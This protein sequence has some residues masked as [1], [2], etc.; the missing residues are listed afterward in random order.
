L[1]ISLVAFTGGGWKETAVAQE[2]KPA[3]GIA[4]QWSAGRTWKVEYLVATPSEEK[5]RSP[6]PIPPE[7]SLWK[8]QVIRAGEGTVLVSVTEESGDRK[9]EITFDWTG[10]A[11][12][13]V[14]KISGSMRDTIV[15]LDPPGGFAGW[16]LRHQVI[17]EWPWLPITPGQKREFPI[18]SWRV[19]ESA[20]AR[21]A[22]LE[23]TMTYIDRRSEEYA[24]TRRVTQMWD[25]SHPWWLS[26]SIEAEY[27]IGSEKS[28]QVLVEGKLI[29]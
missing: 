13:R 1:T 18:H 25:M 26:A 17:F 2:H 12:H 23:T 6:A 9:Y 14:V 15:E 3:S 29:R 4:S 22:I 21:G 8:Y 19:V 27:Q 28:R 20:A 16:S 10:P 5:H 11:L 24:E 7:R